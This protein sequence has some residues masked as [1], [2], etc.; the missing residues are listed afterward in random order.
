MDTLLL[1]IKYAGFAALIFAWWWLVILAYREGLGHAFLMFL[2]GWIYGIIFAVMHWDEARKPFL[3]GLLAFGVIV[4]TNIASFALASREM[5][6][7]EPGRVAYLK[8]QMVQQ[9][10]ANIIAGRKPAASPARAPLFSNAAA[11]L[12]EPAAGPA[13]RSAPAASNAPT[14]KSSLLNLMAGKSAPPDQPAAASDWDQARA[15][16]RVGGVM[17]TGTQTFATVNQQIVKV[18]DELAVELNGRPYRFKV[19]QI[20][21]YHKTV[22]FDPV[23]P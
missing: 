3:I 18:N 11:A 2:C 8:D 20:N 15:L 1:V 17:Q 9:I 19:R 5:P 22:Q 16:L 4:G 6:V 14:L 7:Q 10:T 13:P 23:E 21:L 12:A